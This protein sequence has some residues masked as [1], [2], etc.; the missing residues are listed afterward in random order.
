[1][2]DSINYINKPQINRKL[3]LKNLTLNE[4]NIY[5]RLR[6]RDYKQAG[7]VAGIS[8]TR[9]RQILIGY[10]LPLSSKLI[11]Q[12]ADGWDIEPV[13]LTL[14][15]QAVDNKNRTVEDEQN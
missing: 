13:K 1:M 2:V 10:K 7:I 9:V 3:I 11:N 15:F 14:L 8:E 4:L 6:F 12:I 5:L